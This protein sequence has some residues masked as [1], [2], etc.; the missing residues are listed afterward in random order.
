MIASLTVGVTYPGAAENVF[1]VSVTG[2]GQFQ[3]SKTVRTNETRLLSPATINNRNILN[4]ALGQPLNSALPPNR[5]LA[6]V[7]NCAGAGTLAVYDPMTSNVVATVATLTSSNLLMASNVFCKTV[8]GQRHCSGKSTAFAALGEMTL[9][10]TG[11]RGTNAIDGGSLCLYVS[12]ALDAHECAKNVVANGLGN[13]DVTFTTS[14]R[15]PQTHEQVDVTGSIRILV[16]S[17][18]LTTGRKLGTIQGN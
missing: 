11:N 3:E 14:H 12:G 8:E 16:Q 15:D 4:L 5:I 7:V 17:L 13:I 1:A 9:A 18:T 6:L 2:R 10:A